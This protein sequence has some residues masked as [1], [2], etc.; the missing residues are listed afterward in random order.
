MIRWTLE[1]NANE[2]TGGGGRGTSVSRCLGLN[3]RPKEESGSL[4]FSKPTPWGSLS[5]IQPCGDPHINL[6]EAIM[7]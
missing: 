4:S 5:S 7:A 6:M 1:L 2:G 3:C